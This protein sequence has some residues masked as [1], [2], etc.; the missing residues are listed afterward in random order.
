MEI[1]LTG[2]DRQVNKEANKIVNAG[3]KIKQVGR[4]TF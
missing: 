2:A 1:T 4:E 3:R